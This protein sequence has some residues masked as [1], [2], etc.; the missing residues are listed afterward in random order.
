MGRSRKAHRFRAAAVAVALT[1]CAG[2]AEAGLG[3]RW[4]RFERRV[5]IF[6]PGGRYLTRPIERRVPKLSVN[7]TYYLWSDTL[8]SGAGPVGFRERDFRTLQ[9]QN[10]FE[11][12][13]QYRHSESLQ[14]TSI[15][16]ALY[17]A[18]YSIEGADGLFAPKTHERFRSYQSSKDVIREA[19]VSYRT[20][21]FDLVLGK[22]QIAW[23][24]MDGRFIDVINGIDARESVQL[25]ASDY[26]VRRIPVWMA[27][28]T[29]YAGPLS[30]NLLWIPDFEGDEN[31]VYGSPWFPQLVPPSDD[32]AR[33]DHALL[34]RQ[35]NFL[36]DRVR[37]KDRP[38]WDA[39]NDQ[40]V[41]L[42][43]DVETGALTWGLIYFYSFDKTPS[44]E[45]VGT[46]S[47]ANGTHAILS[48]KHRRLH[49]FGLTADYSTTFAGV[50]WVGHLPMVL[51]L[52]ALLSK[53]VPFFDFFEREAVLAGEQHDGLVENETLR[54][55]IAFEF[56]FP[57]NT[58][59]I[60]QPSVFYTVDWRRGLSPGFGGAFADEWALIP[61]FFVDR[62]FRFTRDRLSTSLTLSPYLSGPARDFQGLK[63]K[64]V[65]S[66]EFSQ[67]IEGNLIY[68]DYSGGS[69]DEL[70]GQYKRYDNIGF[71][72]KYEF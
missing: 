71:E 65:V 67:Y 6:D 72:F 52:E 9:F 63:T 30:I 50:P 10:L 62:P 36:G 17:D 8:T 24:K 14:F 49:Q 25:E 42:R 69:K 37:V 64:L 2:A 60:F 18:S 3:D 61:V 47:D 43:V 34:D 11:L 32:V 56:A 15:T 59:V 23:G 27:N 7:G 70:Y 13:L 31:P 19:Y 55:A 22:Q 57:Q 68:T 21:R 39:I 53:D 16:H 48:R 28:A 45:I 26:E 12:E 20:L 35:V 1:L 33:H 51:R 41:A 5:A 46:F 66:Y 4:A 38:N 54:A 58:T 29:Y 44:D 40:Q